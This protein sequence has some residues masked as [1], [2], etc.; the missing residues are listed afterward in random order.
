M[1]AGS[2]PSGCSTRSRCSP[3][4]WA[5][6]CTRAGPGSRMPL[7]RPV[8]GHGVAQCGHA[9]LDQRAECRESLH[10]GEYFSDLPEPALTVMAQIAFE[11]RIMAQMWISR[12]CRASLPSAE[13]RSS[14]WRQGHTRLR[15][16]EFLRLGAGD[17]SRNRQRGWSRTWESCGSS[18]VVSRKGGLPL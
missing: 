15:E 13:V 2:A 11:G 14:G 6:S 16:F 3:Q 10:A 8:H 7:A 1:K 9:A 17:A 5:K 4:P 12:R 18:L